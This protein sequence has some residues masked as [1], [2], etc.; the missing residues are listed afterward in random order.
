[1]KSLLNAILILSGLALIGF[2][3]YT[4]SFKDISR[5]PAL[6]R[7]A[8]PQEEVSF[9]PTPAKVKEVTKKPKARPVQYG[10]INTYVDGVDVRQV[11]LFSSDNPSTRSFV[12]GLK[13]R[14]RVK[15]L[16]RGNPY[17]YVESVN[18]SSCKGYCMAGFVN[19]E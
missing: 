13:N 11:N 5:K 17:W 3:V 12:C 18:D 16:R 14:D 1:M 2:I 7:S 9:E 15:V 8:E 4:H 6:D 19:L 10:R